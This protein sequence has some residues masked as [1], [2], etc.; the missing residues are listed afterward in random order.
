MCVRIE[1]SNTEYD[2]YVIE[3][4]LFVLGPEIEKFKLNLGKKTFRTIRESFFNQI[5]MKFTSYEEDNDNQ[6]SVYCASWQN[7]GWWLN[8]C[9]KTYLT[10]EHNNYGHGFMDD[11][12]MGSNGYRL[13]STIKMRLRPRQL[14][15][16]LFKINF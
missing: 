15:N 8:T 9:H 2:K 6:A 4:D 3:Y 11:A 16:N 1:L 7:A 10:C 5:E 12:R 14:E 13:F